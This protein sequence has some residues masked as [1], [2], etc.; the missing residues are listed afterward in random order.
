MFISNAFNEKTISLED[1]TL[2]WAG[3]RTYVELELDVDTRAQAI[4]ISGTPGGDG[5]ATVLDVQLLAVRDIAQQFI[6]NFLGQRVYEFPDIT[7]P[8]VEGAEL[9]LGTGRLRISV[10]EP[11]CTQRHYSDA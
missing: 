1:C 6:R 10:S 11:G 3:D 5:I 4:A 9:D 7:P 8:V 2:R